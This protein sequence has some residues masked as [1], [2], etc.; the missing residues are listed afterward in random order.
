M[1]LAN[2]GRPV[3]RCVFSPDG[4]RILA[5]LSHTEIGLWDAEHGS[6]I[7]TFSDPYPTAAF[8]FSPDSQR[9]VLRAGLTHRVCDA[10]SG[11]V[12]RAFDFQGGCNYSPDGRRF[13]SV[14]PLVIW[15]ARTG[16]E[17][18]RLSEGFPSD[19]SL[20]RCLFASDGRH[21]MWWSER[22]GI[23]IWDALS[24]KR[25]AEI[26]LSG[27]MFLVPR[28]SQR[29]L[30]GAGPVGLR[31][32]RLHGVEPAPQVVTA[33]HLYR[34]DLHAFEDTASAMCES[35]AQRFEAPG[36]VLDAI[37][38]ITKDVALNIDD[39][40]CESLPEDAWQER[41]LR[42]TCAHCHVPVHFNPFVVDG[43]PL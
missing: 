22:H 38:Q 16:G 25:V 36:G 9:I 27:V 40:P 19:A 34:F 33:T 8:A 4:R 3:S 42:S 12:I 20:R 2:S 10:Q 1:Q 17:L 15:D 37:A 28:M 30:A 41:R 35:C 14:W 5:P 24:R 23:E 43:R 32:F 7:A 6:L 21:V 13:V 11:R 18:D 26:P 39:S 29:T 31:I